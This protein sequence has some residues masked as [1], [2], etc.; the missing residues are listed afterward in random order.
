MSSDNQMPTLRGGTPPPPYS[1]SDIYSATPRSPRSAPSAAGSGSVSGHGPTA[2]RD[3]VATPMSPTSTTGSVIFTPE[4]SPTVSEAGIATPVGYQSARL[5]SSTRYL[6]SRPAPTST[7]IWVPSSYTIS[8]TPNTV[9]DDIPYPEHWAAYDITPQDWA[10]FINFLLPDH[11]SVA[12][13]AIL[14]GK[15]KSE[16]GSDVKSTIAD[17]SVKSEGQVPD[18]DEW[19]RK[20]AEAE[21]LVVQWNTSFFSPRKVTVTLQ[22]ELPAQMPGGWE[23]AFED[24]PEEIPQDGPSSQRDA[25]PQHRSGGGWGG[26]QMDERGIRFGNSFVADSSG[27][28]MG[29]LVMDSHGIRMDG[30]DD[31]PYFGS[32]RRPVPFTPGHH[33]RARGRGHAAGN[34]GPPRGRATHH[35]QSGQR[36]RSSSTSSSSSSDSSISSASSESIGSLPDQDDIRE[37]QL[38]FYIARLEQWT[39]NPHETRSKADVKQLKAELKAERNN[40]VALDPSLDKKALKKQTKMLI[41]E[42][43]NLKRQQ[44]KERK[45]RKKAEKKEKKQRKKE[46]KAARRDHRRD[47]RNERREQRGRGRGRGHSNHHPFIP[48]M[49]AFQNQGIPLRPFE[50]RV[51]PVNVPPINVPPVIVPEVRVNVPGVRVPPPACGGYWPRR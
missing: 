33:P 42:W 41:Q 40:A 26:F 19:P 13:E 35:C 44:K 16:D 47:H 9:P 17:G 18:P 6:E 15:T 48:E 1:E 22:P 21:A 30:Q 39:A 31:V 45:Q 2:P 28:R 36:S 12:N 37:E 5:L 38:P 4:T 11:D 25:M 49:P 29:G 8:L 7:S 43:K 10:T 32:S 24:P 14:G 27:L 34:F 20:R 50:V 3:H 23:A 51:P 46:M